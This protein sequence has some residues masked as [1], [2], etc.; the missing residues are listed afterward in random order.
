MTEAL[1]QYVRISWA[2]SLFEVRKFNQVTGLND[3]VQMDGFP[4]VLDEC[5]AL[6]LQMLVFS[7]ASYTAV[8]DRLIAA[9]DRT[10][11]CKFKRPS[12]KVRDLFSASATSSKV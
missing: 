9:R 3:V 10:R 2:D 12:S 11:D 4:A 7:I 5:L 8:M 1:V 6:Y